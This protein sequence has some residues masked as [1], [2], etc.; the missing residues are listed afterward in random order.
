[1]GEHFTAPWEPNPAPDLLI[2]QGLQR[3]KNIK[4]CPGAHSA[5]L[6]SPR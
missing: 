2:A 6:P 4:L 5:A 1:M 3:T